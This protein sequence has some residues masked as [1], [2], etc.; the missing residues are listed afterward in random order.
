MQY[1]IPDRVK[2]LN[3]KGG[4][5]GSVD[6]VIYR[7]SDE[8]HEHLVKYGYA[9]LETGQRMTMR[10]GIWCNNI[11]LRDFATPYNH[12]RFTWVPIFCYRRDRDGMPYG[13]IRDLRSPQDDINARKARAYYLMSSEKIF[14]EDGAIDGN[15][16]EF[17][18]EANRPD[19]LAKLA[20]GALSGNKIRFEN[21][22]E[23]ANQH[24]AVGREAEQ[25]MHNIAGV[26]PEQ[27]GQSKRDLSGVAIKALESQGATTNSTLFAN[28]YFSLQLAGE[29]ELSNIEQFMNTEQT[30]RITGE[31]QR[32]EFMTINHVDEETGEM[33]DS[34]TRAKADFKISK[35]DYRETVRQA[36]METLGQLIMNLAKLG[37]KAGEV[38]L[39]MIDVYVDLFDNLAVKEELVSRIRKITGQEGVD[40]DLTPEEKQQKEQSKQEHAA[41]Q[42]QAQQFQQ[43]MA[44]L[45]KRIKEAEASGKESKA[46]KDKVDAIS[47]SIDGFRKA[48]EAAGM[49]AVAPQLVSAGDTLIQEAVKAIE[50]PGEQQQ[51]QPEQQQQPQQEPLV[52]PIQEGGIPQ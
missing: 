30:V 7:P 37:G 24:L 8:L 17:R 20:K 42:Q 50:G 51:A 31:E 11:Y 44:L 28:Y 21:G 5:Y 43:E 19:G 18:E 45:E 4:E 13:M 32:H 23:K 48:M 16:W 36:N 33:Q 9:N 26:T 15:I 22:I 29:I 35:S 6:G 14:Y 34:I 1:R 46:M 40:E 47:K 25:F 49:V 52:K 2:I 3:V 39:A 10:H 38:S 41:V 27:Q 12:N